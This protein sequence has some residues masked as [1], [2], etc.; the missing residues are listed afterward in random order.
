MPIINWVSIL[1]KDGET[2]DE[3]LY[4]AKKKMDAVARLEVTINGITLKKGLEKY[5]AQSP[6]FNVTLPEENILESP[7]GHTRLV[8]D[9]YWIFLGPLESATELI[10]FGSCSSGVNKFGV[11]YH[12]NI[13]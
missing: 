12:V 13:V 10:T 11:N 1:D 3:L 6:F 9:G 4:I 5:R 2:D 7:A 8:S